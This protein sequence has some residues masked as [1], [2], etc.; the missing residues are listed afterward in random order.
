MAQEEIY[1][2]AQDGLAEGT[3]LGTDGCS[4]GLTIMTHIVRTEDL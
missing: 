3:A 4:S 1:G 2:E